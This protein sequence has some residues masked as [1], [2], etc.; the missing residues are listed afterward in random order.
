MVR[1]RD[2]EISMDMLPSMNARS[3]VSPKPMFR[4]RMTARIFGMTMAIPKTT[5]ISRTMSRGKEGIR[6][7]F[8]LFRRRVG[9]GKKHLNIILL[10]LFNSCLPSSLRP[11]FAGRYG[12]NEPLFSSID[13]SNYS[14]SCVL[15]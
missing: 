10:L 13:L 7:S 12:L 11:L 3:S 5:T 4:A 8:I 6:I 14:V 2:R 9:P 15:S 1:D